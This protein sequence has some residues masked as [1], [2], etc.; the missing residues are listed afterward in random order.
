M[1]L[2]EEWCCTLTRGLVVPRQEPFIQMVA[3]GLL[4]GRPVKAELLNSLGEDAEKIG[5]HPSSGVNG[6]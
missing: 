2:W 5:I 1:D 3:C 4:G 6:L